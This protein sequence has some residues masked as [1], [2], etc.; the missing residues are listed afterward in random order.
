M[1]RSPRPHTRIGRFEEVKENLVAGSAKRTQSLA[2]DHEPIVL[3]ACPRRVSGLGCPEMRLRR[4]FVLVTSGHK[5]VAH[6]AWIPKIVRC[7]FPGGAACALLLLLVH[8]GSRGSAAGYDLSLMSNALRLAL[9]GL[10]PPPAGAA[11]HEL[12]RFVRDLQ[13]RALL[14]SA[15][16][17]ALVLVLVNEAWAIAVVGVALVALVGNVAYLTLRLRSDEFSS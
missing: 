8:C 13:L 3:G 2:G 16:V 9:L 7:F 10:E 6:T 14:P 1:R 5:F 12:L 11:R 15:A 17:F 4:G